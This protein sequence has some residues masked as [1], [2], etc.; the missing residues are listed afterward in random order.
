[1]PV[2]GK[3]DELVAALGVTVGLGSVAL[4]ALIP[5]LG[6]TARS[7][8]RALGAPSAMPMRRADRP[9][10]PLEAGCAARPGAEVTGAG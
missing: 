10:P 5:V 3:G 4:Q 2:R 9:V 7:I 1:V 8:S 6:A